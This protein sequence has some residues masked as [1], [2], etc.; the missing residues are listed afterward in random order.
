MLAVSFT[1]LF[2][3]LLLLLIYLI[4]SAML[5]IIRN[6]LMNTMKRELNMLQLIALY[7]TNV[8]NI[9]III[10]NNVVILIRFSV[11]CP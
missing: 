4:Q 9:T 5:A 2:L 11:C 6:S 8:F 7:N 10:I 1:S 3:L